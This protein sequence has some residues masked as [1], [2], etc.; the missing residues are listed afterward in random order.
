MYYITVYLMSPP[1]THTLNTIMPPN[2]LPTTEWQGRGLTHVHFFV[3]NEHVSVSH[4]YW[5]FALTLMI[6]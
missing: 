1:V 5:H 2:M 4:S 6:G 3:F